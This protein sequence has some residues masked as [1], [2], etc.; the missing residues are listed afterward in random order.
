VLRFLVL[1]FAVLWVMATIGRFTRRLGRR[2]VAPIRGALPVPE[3]EPGVDRL[4]GVLR[5]VLGTIL[6]I[7]FAGTLLV[8]TDLPDIVVVLIA[9]AVAGLVAGLVTEWFVTEDDA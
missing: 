5:M 4:I 1:A 7:A 8:L 3:P 2:P 6:V 9:A